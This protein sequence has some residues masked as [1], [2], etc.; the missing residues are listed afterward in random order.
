MIEMLPHS[1]TICYCNQVTKGELVRAISEGATTV[2]A[3]HQVTGAG[4]G[5]KC[6]ELHPEGRCCHS[7]IVELLGLSGE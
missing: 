2:E 5:G 4:F 3:L 1:A 7:D 6:K